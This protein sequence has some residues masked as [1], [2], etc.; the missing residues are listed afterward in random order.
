MVK[1]TKSVEEYLGSKYAISILLY[2]RTNPGGCKTDV[3]RTI[4]RER[5]VF[6]RLKEGIAL[7][8]ICND[9]RPKP[10]NKAALTLTDEGQRIADLLRQI[11]GEAKE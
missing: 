8:L 7:G 1:G 10:H 6:L 5:T 2:L 3:M 11:I 9:L 4:G